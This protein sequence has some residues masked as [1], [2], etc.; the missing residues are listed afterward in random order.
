MSKKQIY[1]LDIFIGGVAYYLAFVL[2]FSSITFHNDF[3]LFLKTLPFVIV[4][5]IVAF[6][7]FNLH[8]GIW[9]Y[10]S[11]EDLLDILKATSVSTLSI[12]FVVFTLAR[13]S[14]PRSVP[15]IDWL[16]TMLF[17][18]GIRVLIRIRAEV[19]T[20]STLSRPTRILIVGAGDSGSMILKE[21]N[22]NPQIGYI[23]IGFVDD[24]H[25]KQGKSIQGIRILGTTSD[26]P[27]LVQ[28]Y[29][30]EEI[31]IAIPSAS[32]EQLRQIVNKC[33]QAKVKFKTLPGL[34]D[35][36]D[37]TVSIAQVKEVDVV[38]LLRR[39]AIELDSKNI[40][41]H[42]LGK[43]VMVTGAGGSIGGELCRQIAK[44]KPAELIL[45][46]MAETPLFWIELHLRREFPN[47]NITA[48]LADIKDRPRIEEIIKS[49]GPQIIYHAAAYKHVPMIERNVIEG[50]KNNIF[51]TQVL[52]DMATKYMVESFVMISTDKAVNPINFM[53]LS[54]RIGELYVQAIS[55]KSKTCFVVV[56]FGNVLDSNG[57]CL[58]LFKQQIKAGLPI[59][60]THP[61]VKRF[62]MTLPEAGQLIVEAGAMGKGGEIFILKMGEQIKIV[63]IARDLVAFSGGKPEE[64]KFS[65]I[66]L[67]PGEK[68]SEELIG[69]NEKFQLTKDEKIL[70]IHSNNH[71]H[72]VE[73]TA[74]LDE[75]HQYMEDK[76]KAVEKCKSI[77]EKYT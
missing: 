37:G 20:K 25:D 35:I 4:I 18:C 11:I 61:E 40:S 6:H 52:V 32:G 63:D 29:G 50:I 62:F 13:E 48:L 46:D 24:A 14:Y 53:G 74:E 57:S 16:L 75:L 5:K 76:K 60:I 23:P 34:A 69:K 36:I 31:I 12:I 39:K 72:Y 55:S 68:L 54:K 51:G 45:L 64:V 49:I 59:T 9:R 7:F 71:I 33:K 73:L 70:I 30:I 77:V 44:F 56:R 67:R 19:V 47:L 27:H 22:T 65:F 8:K 38:D 2:R 1:W 58:P 3:D 26:I 21:L 15:I 17:L 66:G 10:A 41:I 43:K 28:K 42:L